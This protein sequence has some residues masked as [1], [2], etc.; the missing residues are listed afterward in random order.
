MVALVN[1]LTQI[2]IALVA[3]ANLIVNFYARNAS[4]A[5]IQEV[6]EVRASVEDNAQSAP[7]PVAGAARVALSTFPSP[8]AARRKTY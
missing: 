1:Y 7:Q 3:L 2:L 6:L 5:R 4:A 8:T